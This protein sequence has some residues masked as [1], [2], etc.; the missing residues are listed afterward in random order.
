MR[1]FASQHSCKEAK[2]RKTI[3]ILHFVFFCQSR[4][5]ITMSGESLPLY[6]RLQHHIREVDPM[7]EIELQQ[8]ILHTVLDH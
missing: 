4:K 2:N 3:K 6:A 7:I 1:H 5:I 8:K